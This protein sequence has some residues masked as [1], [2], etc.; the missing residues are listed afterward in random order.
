MKIAE[1]FLKQ[2]ITVYIGCSLVYLYY[3]IIGR[4]ITYSDVLNKVDEK[5]GMKKYRY[6]AF[7]S[8]VIFIIILVVLLKV[9]FG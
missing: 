9:L 8:G 3:R 5:T 1:F 7:Y 6:I 2:I 4:K